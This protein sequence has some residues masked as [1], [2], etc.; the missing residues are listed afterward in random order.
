[1]MLYPAHN[2]MLSGELNQLVMMCQQLGGRL[3]DQDM[4]ATLNGVL[5]DRIMCGCMKKNIVKRSENA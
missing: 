4:Q 5:G 1:M 2:I 3:C